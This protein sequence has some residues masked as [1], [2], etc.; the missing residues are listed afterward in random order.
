MKI[1]GF[2][3]LSLALLF[4][5]SLTGCGEETK[6]S[7]RVPLVKTLV[8]EPGNVS[9]HNIYAG[10]V[11]GRYESSLSFQV[12]GRVLSR[13]VQAGS[14][15]HAGDVLM[16]LDPRDVLQQSSQGDAQVTSA[17]AQLELATS[18]LARYQELYEAGAISA[19]TLEQY[20][21]N[22][23]VAASAYENAKAQAAQG[24]NALSYASLTANADG[25]VSSVHVEEGQ[26][27]A[28]GQTAL[29]LVQ[30][31]ELEVEIHVPENHI[32][33]TRIGSSA[34]ITFWAMPE[35]VTGVIREISPMAEN[36]SRTYTVRISLPSPPANLQ[37]GMTASASLASSE[38]EGPGEVFLLPLSAVYQTGKEPQVWVVNDQNKV[39]LKTISVEEFSDNQVA[40]KG[41]SKGERIVIAGVHNLREGQEVRLGGK[42]L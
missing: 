15:V 5:V 35:A 6:K 19:A 1:K 42:E 26:V 9:S 21:T 4:V 3:S 8:A 25:V 23:N 14:V 40:V 30:T 37:L 38:G 7:A 28:A 31:G 12:G 34:T 29:S 32:G 39:Q 17:A 18:N 22:Y 27:V 2:L 13:N 36:A 41:L 20:Q 33:E 24:H 11:R 10:T 16:T